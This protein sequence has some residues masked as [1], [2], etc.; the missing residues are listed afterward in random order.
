M[1]TDQEWLP[2]ESAPR[3]GTAILLYEKWR[4]ADVPR[5]GFW[6]K[7][8]KVWAVDDGENCHV[9]DITGKCMTIIDPINWQPLPPPPKGPQS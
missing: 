2:I 5:S 6:S 4:N 3:D 8:Y 9:Y 7:L 1:P